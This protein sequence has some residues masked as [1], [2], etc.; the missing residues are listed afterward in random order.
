MLVPTSEFRAMA[1]R[2]SQ[3]I[4]VFG[5]TEDAFYAWVLGDVTSS[6]AA[7]LAA[8]LDQVLAPDRSTSEIAAVFNASPGEVIFSN[9][10]DVQNFLVG[11]RDRL[12][13]MY[14]V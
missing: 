8:F 1:R 14:R 13:T 4:A 3:D 5:D 12:R 11:V 2:L 7:N 10:V 9:A 6:N